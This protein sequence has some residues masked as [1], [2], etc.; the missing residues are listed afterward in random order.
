MRVCVSIDLDN[1]QD[2][3]SLVDPDGEESAHSFYGDAVPRYLDLLDQHELRGTFFVI[4]RDTAVPEHRRWIRAIADRGHEVGN[5]SYSHPYNFRALSRGEKELEIDQ[6]DAALADVLGERTVGFRTP[7]CEVDCETLTILA[8]RGYLYDSSVF[9]SPFMWAFM[10]YGRLFVRHDSYQ[11]GEFLAPLAPATPYVPSA[12]R[13]HH[14]RGSDTEA[15][16]TVLEIP[17]SVVSPLR[18]P[19]YSTLL[20]RLG[21]GFFSRILRWY[22]DQQTE[23]HSLFHMIELAALDDTSLGRALERTPALAVPLERR[24]LFVDHCF[25]ELGAVGEPSTL[26]ELAKSYLDDDARNPAV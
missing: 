21:C 22:G 6:G 19:F 26:R 9:P 1:Y 23:L 12:K 25:G 10:L 8:E 15:A 20:R 4:G 13:L 2:Y 5:H 24:V 16:P 3:R 17:F 18:I 7:S 14:R 11:L